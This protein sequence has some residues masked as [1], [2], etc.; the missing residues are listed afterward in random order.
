MCEFL[1]SE[2]D[3]SRIK[4]SDWGLSVEKEPLGSELSIQNPEF[5][6]AQG[7]REKNIDFTQRL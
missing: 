3:P 5:S 6:T 1:R 4:T 2:E 7:E